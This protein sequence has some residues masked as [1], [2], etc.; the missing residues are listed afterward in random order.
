MPIIRFKTSVLLVIIFA[1]SELLLLGLSYN[2]L[3]VQIPVHFNGAGIPNRYEEKY[4]AFI[5]LGV[6]VIVTSIPLLVLYL[7]KNKLS[8]G[9]V[10]L[11]NLFLIIL[12]LGN[13]ASMIKLV[14]LGWGKY[15][16]KSGWEPFLIEKGAI[17]AG[18]V[19]VFLLL[20]S[21]GRRKI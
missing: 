19:I 18:T 7:R 12:A 9:A 3:P 6:D 8:P 10:V 13:L 4:F 11:L 16:Y 20:R 2:R 1:L 14:M 5:L 21:L 17:A 15:L